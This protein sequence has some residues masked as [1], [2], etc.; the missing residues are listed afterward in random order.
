MEAPVIEAPQRPSSVEEI[1][2]GDKKAFADWLAKPHF[3]PFS[4]RGLDI[5][6]AALRY[7]AI[8]QRLL[9]ISPDP[10]GVR[11]VPRERNR[12]HLDLAVVDITREKAKGRMSSEETADDNSTLKL[13]LFTNPHKVLHVESYWDWGELRGK[14]IATSFY[15][16]LRKIA[17][18]MGFRFITG[19]NRE[20]NV[21]FFRGK[22][23]RV[24]LGQIKPEYQYLFFRDTNDNRLH[25]RTIDIL[26]PEDRARFLI[27]G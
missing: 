4:P 23:G 7:L 12:N 2:A 18:Q 17:R 8:P 5:P 11:V 14:G 6:D 22:L 27:E 19:E 24:T 10:R 25:L 9:E 13:E 1:I 20:E 16:R 21:G 15:Q 3:N 26:N